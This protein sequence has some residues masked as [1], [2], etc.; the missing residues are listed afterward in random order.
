[1]VTHR[2]VPVEFI[3]I[4]SGPLPDPSL[5]LPIETSVPFE[6]IE[7][8]RMVSSTKFVAYRKLLLGVI[9]I[10]LGPCFDPAAT[11][12]TRVR[13][14]VVVLRVNSEMVPELKLVTN[15]RV[16]GLAVPVGVA[17]GAVP[18]GVAVGVLLAV[19]VGKIEPPHATMPTVPARSS[20]GG[21]IAKIFSAVESLDNNFS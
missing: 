16:E 14:P 2:N 9:A 1:L 8:S 10:P 12:P 18:V 5:T 3:A 21:K 7:Y 11:A 20:K 17:V 19:T 15:A 4:I 13:P 6:W